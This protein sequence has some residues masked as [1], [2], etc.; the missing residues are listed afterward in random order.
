MAKHK[1][2][3]TGNPDKEGRATDN[4]ANKSMEKDMFT[5]NASS[6]NE[7]SDL[8]PEVDDRQQKVDELNDKYL[9]LYSEF[10]NYRR[11]VSKEKLEIA[12]TA[13]EDV[14]SSLLPVIDDFDRAIV[15]FDEDAQTDPVKQ[16]I[17]LI[18]NK[19]RTIL[20]Q[21][22]LSEIQAIGADF[23]T[24]FHEAVAHIPAPEA[25]QKGKVI[26]ITQKGYLLNGKVIRFAKVVVGS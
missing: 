6:V 23:D 7:E 9:R 21:K 24:D 15:L 1:K 26:D 14:I 18:Y 10:D 8:G 4:M 16:G 19:L 22:G 2:Q 25:G 5:G 12:K 17:V 11:R 20:N 3:E 13:G